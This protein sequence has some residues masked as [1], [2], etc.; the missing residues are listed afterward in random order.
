M[1]EFDIISTLIATA[2]HCNTI[3][4]NKSLVKFT[5]GFETGVLLGQL[6]YWHERSTIK[7]GWVAKTDA[8]FCEELCLSRYALRKAANVLRKRGLIEVRTRMFGRTRMRHYRLRATCLASEWT[9]YVRQNDG[10]LSEI[11]QGLSES[12]QPLSEIE[13]SSISETTAETTHPASAARSGKGKSEKKPALHQSLIDLFCSKWQSARGAKYPFKGRDAVA[14]KTFLAYLRDNDA[15]AGRELEA[16]A[17][18]IDRYLADKSLFVSK[19]HSHSLHWLGQS[20]EGYVAGAVAEPAR[21][22]ALDRVTQERQSRLAAEAAR[23]QAIARCVSSIPVT[24]IP[25]LIIDFKNFTGRPH[26]RDPDP[27]T[28]QPFRQWLYEKF[29]KETP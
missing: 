12:E 29:G 24:D 26:A 18:I 4:V 6:L 27:A 16:A 1:S 23:E 14:A 13:L 7:G 9:M 8:D 11:E 25:Q 3:P 21:V 10:S 28:H 17:K 5:G 15:C 20:L 2:G 19:N 22:A